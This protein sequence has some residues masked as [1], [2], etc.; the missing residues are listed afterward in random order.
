MNSTL[1][2]DTV[3]AMYLNETNT[4]GPYL[5]SE[6]LK[7]ILAP[8]NQSFG[9]NRKKSKMVLYVFDYAARH[10]HKSVAV[11]KMFLPVSSKFEPFKVL[12]GCCPIRTGV[13]Q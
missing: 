8:H 6:R 13:P 10:D 4:N 11:I 5:L 9:K 1:P 3:H 2:T 12:T 7:K